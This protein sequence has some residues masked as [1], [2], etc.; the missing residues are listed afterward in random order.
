M[1]Q[2]PARLRALPSALWLKDRLD[3][4]LG[5]AA[6]TLAAPL[7]ALLAILVRWDS[8]GPALFRQIRAGRGGRGFPMLKFRTMRTDVNPFGDS[9]QSGA[10]PRITRLG[11]WLRESSLDELPQLFNVVSGD[12]SLVGP[13]PLYVQMIPDWTPRQRSRLLVKP[14]LTGLSQVNGRASL[15]IE[16]RL[17]Y[18]VQ[19]VEAFGLRTDLM[20]LWMT[21]RRVIDRHGVYQTVYSQTQEKRV[22]EPA[23]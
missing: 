7:M 11:R 5:A 16:Q 21:V 22:S 15:T 4:L 2:T 8:P 19:Y 17:E 13:R 10:D 1:T 20:I 9:P 3:F 12:M 23:G 14:G 18:D 6:L